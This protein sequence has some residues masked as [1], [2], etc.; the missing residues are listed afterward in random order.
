ARIEEQFDDIADGKQEWPE[1]LRDFYEPFH[2]LVEE[3]LESAD[4][5]TRERIL[6]EDPETGRTILTRLSRRGPVIQLGAPDELE[7]GEKPRYANFPSGVTMDDIDLETAIKLFELPKTLGT[8]EGQEVSV[9]A[10][11]YGPYVKWGEQYVSLSRGEDP[12]DVDMDRAKELIKEKKAA[13]APIATYKG[14]PITKGKGRF[15]PFVK[16]QSTY[17]NVSKKYDFDHLSGADAIALIEAKLE[18]EANRYIQQ[19]ESEKISI[20][21][22]RWGPF[23]RFNR[24]NV[25]LPKVD[26]AR[27]TAEQA[28]ELT[29]E[30]V[31]EIIEAELPGSFGDKKKK[32]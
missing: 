25:K 4:R 19:W 29:L 1:M 26:G 21:N 32:K 31:K 20:E 30:E 13:D 6:G 22:G 2:S 14:L 7:E 15:G 17:A 11:R 23:I 18:K 12:H 5:V 10:G 27:M 8:Y 9:G 24:K 16:W 28:K 3:T